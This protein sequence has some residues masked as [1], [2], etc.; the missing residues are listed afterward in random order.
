MSNWS[1]GMIVPL[2]IINHFKPTRPPK[3][4]VNLDELYPEGMHERDLAI[5]PDP[6]RITLRNFFLWLDRLH[7][8]A[9]RFAR[10]GVHLVPQTGL[11]QGRAVDASNGLKVQTAWRRFFRRC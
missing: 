11:A 5:A 9:E 2:S 6:K 10:R 3:S 4:C 8:F 7:K 1:R